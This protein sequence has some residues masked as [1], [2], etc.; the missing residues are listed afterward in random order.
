MKLIKIYQLL[1]VFLFL[2]SYSYAQM[3]LWYPSVRLTQGFVDR[4]PT[5]SYECN[6]SPGLFS[7]QYEMLAFERYIASYSQI[8]VLKIG[9]V[10]PLDSVLYLTSNVSL[11]RNP[12]I[13]YIG[14]VSGYF[15]PISSIVVVWESNQR[16]QWDIFG[17]AYRNFM[18]GPIFAVDTSNGNKSH[19]S[20]SILNDSVCY[21]AYEKMGDIRFR[22]YNFASFAVQYDTNLTANENAYCDE[23][24]VARYGVS[25]N[26]RVVYHLQKPDT[27]RAIYYRKVQVLPNWTAPD[28]IAWLGDNKF[29][30]FTNDATEYGW[31]VAFSSNRQ[32]YW[33]TY[34]TTFTSSKSQEPLFT[35]NPGFDYTQFKNALVSMPVITD[36]VFIAAGGYFK[37]KNDTL[38]LM[39]TGW[40]FIPTDSNVVC[41][42]SKHPIL[43]M[44][45]HIYYTPAQ[46]V[47]WAVYNR[48]SGNVSNLWGRR[49]VL[50]INNIKKIS[51][52]ISENYVLEQ[53]Y[54]NPF[55]AVTTIRFS[56]G[57]FDGNI[58]GN[59][60]VILKIYDVQGREIK[61]LIN[62]N[63]TR[64]IYEVKFD[65]SDLP[66]GVYYYKLTT[67]NYSETKRMV[68]L[69]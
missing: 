65:G 45:R 69:K 51:G 50:Y 41:D 55:N 35:S 18:W 31:G 38:K 42:T 11:K 60:F 57:R 46:V 36:Y 61:T 6:L 16:G 40:Y 26:P 54:P 66:S 10:G 7:Y 34:A 4:N 8:C 30:S 49:M 47:F 37:R 62:E 59:D 53:N 33:N 20:V 24:Y 68:L 64:G 12:A 17:R 13:S 28:T 29:N 23:P 44:N 15:A 39:L 2:C 22:T 58:S 3:G 63:L 48:D 14:Y 27:K 21:V 1:I 25:S 19:P 67:G 9:P 43:T 5:F 32:G 52:E 56:I